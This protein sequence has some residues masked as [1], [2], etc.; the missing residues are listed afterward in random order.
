MRVHEAVRPDG[1][2]VWIW[3]PHHC[4]G[5]GGATASVY[6]M[7]CC[8]CAPSIR[9]PRRPL[10]ASLLQDKIE[11]SNLSRQVLFRGTDVDKFKSA[12]AAE[13][14]LTA[15]PELKVRALMLPVGT[16][17][18]LAPFNDAFWRSQ[19]CATRQGSRCAFLS[20]LPDCSL[21]LLDDARTSL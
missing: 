16:D 5:Y 19:V 15:N 12:C 4:D 3:R 7:S 6:I 1:R 2:G 20:V 14:V 17:T 21:Y 10:S 18:E 13:A 8:A 9:G 11:A